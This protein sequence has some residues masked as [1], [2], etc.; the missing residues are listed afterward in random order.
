MARLSTIQAWCALAS[1][2]GLD[3]PAF[4]LA[5]AEV[6]L[7]QGRLAESQ[8]LAESAAAVDSGSD[9]SFR[10]LCVAGRAAHVASRE[11][12]ALEL[13]RRAEE[14]AGTGAKRRD[15]L[16]GQVMCEIEL[17][18]PEATETMR[19]LKA[20]VRRSDPREVV[21]AAA[22]GLSYR[23]KTGSID[24]D[25]ADVAHELLPVVTDPLVESAFQSVYSNLLALSARYEEA[26]QVSSALVATADR[27][28]LDFAMPY[29]LCAAAM[30]HAGLRHWR[31]AEQCLDKAAEAARVGRHADAEHS[32]FAVR[33]RILAEE[34]RQQTALAMEVPSLSG[35]TPATRAEVLSS[36][37]LA[38][39]S[40]GRVQEALAIVSAIRG[41]THAVETAVLVVATEAIAAL[42]C[43]EEGAIELVAGLEEKA[44]ST[45]ALDLLVAAYRSTPELLTV[46]LRRSKH[47]DR[48]A[49]PLRA[50]GDEDLA[51]AV[52]E[53]IS[54]TDPRERLSPREREVYDLL[55]QGLSNRQI[56]DLLFIS[57]STVKLHAHH[58]YD[59]VGV[60]SR[61]ALAV[62][63]AL[64]RG[65][66]AT[67]A[68]G[69]SEVEDAS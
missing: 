69:S 35:S 36:R 48:M 8:A 7:R 41:S 32:C 26:L 30:A 68:T 53:P 33:L 25:D 22:Y 34:G 44:F 66:H 57:E 19:Q 38:L 62:Q 6:A 47:P 3:T 16:W 50:V 2:L 64:E 18:L 4:S 14:I 56:A 61:V 27:Y 42:K 46:L 23:Q 28:R 49:G 55:R 13:F 54:D 17:E 63:A 21:R 65:N 59:K 5:R 45:G 60:R 15:A 24:L 58:V 12:E 37:A 10:A 67:F 11:E 51:L 39:A 20:G 29:A 40:T 1:E 43:N 9:F 52:G 31:Q